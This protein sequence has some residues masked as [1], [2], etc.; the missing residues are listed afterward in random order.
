VARALLAHGAQVAV[1]DDHPTDALQA[2]ASELGVH[3]VAAPDDTELSALVAAADGVLPS[4]GVPE[5]H[6][7]FAIAERSGVPVRSEFDLAASW[8]RRPCLAITGTDGKTTVTTMVTAMLEASGRRAV[9]AGNV[10]VPLVAA[11][12]DPEP[13]VFVVEASSFR[14]S[15][16]T[17]FRPRV[18]TWLNIADDHQDVHLST[19]GYRA[20]KARL[21]ANLTADDLA[22]ANVDDAVVLA[23]AEG[24]PRL[25]TFGLGGKGS[26]DWYVDGTTLR[27]PDGL[28]LVDVE[29]LHRALP[30]DVAN[31]LAASA[32][33]LN[34]GATAEGARR[35][36][37]EFRGLPH[38]VELVGEAGGV[39]YYDDSKATAPH[40]TMAAVAGFPSVVLIAGGRN[41][42]LDLSP[43]GTVAPHVRAVVAIGEAAAEV[44]AAFHDRP[45]TDATSMDEAVSA[46]QRLAEPGDVVLLS[47]ACASFDWYRSYGE[48]GDASQRAVRTITAAATD[49]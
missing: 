37:R 42:G 26:A 11:I 33:A 32:T 18:A 1:V 14:L 9:A 3:L 7:V 31:A 6:P 13:E 20:A 49:E 27:G 46:A 10:D 8:D 5:S 34:G 21:W 22:V 29:E 36:L 25:Q 39:R 28:E 12:A 15:H 38:R 24:V 16:A 35:A 19:S 30:H 17:V 45:V 2:A 40:A 4:P 43:L 48:R 41:K 47:P 44:R 23:C